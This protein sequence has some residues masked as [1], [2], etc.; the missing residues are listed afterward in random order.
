ML[1]VNQHVVPIAVDVA[2]AFAVSGK[3]VTLFTGYIETGGNPLHPAIKVVRSVTYRR[4]STLTRLWTWFA[5]SIHYLFFLL[6]RRGSEPVLVVTNPPVAPI[7]T[8][9]VS[10]VRAFTYF[11]QVYD[12]YPEALVQ[13]GFIKAD[14]LFGRWWR[15]VNRRVFNNAV[16][17][18]TLSES[19]HNALL[20]YASTP[21]IKVIHNWVDADFI[22]PIPRDQN[23]FLLERGWN[24]KTIV[25]YAGNMGLTHDLESIVDAAR[26]LRNHTNLLFL[27]VG[28]G[29]KKQKLVEM[30]RKDGLNN[31]IFLPYQS[32]KEFPLVLAA[33]DIGVV[34]LGTGGEGISVPSKTYSA[35][36][37]GT[38][39]LIIAPQESEL[40]RLVINHK[41]GIAVPPG[42]PEELAFQIES[43]VSS[44]ESLRTYQDASRKA[45]LLFSPKNAFL[46]VQDIFPDSYV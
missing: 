1:I 45:S 13:A 46:Y 42:R 37:A 16:R 2:N 28:D 24:D 44:P 33:A 34:T 38:C 29:G 36:A 9:W 43:L 23:R 31:V 15:S 10:R 30:V 39:L 41:A 21:R 7:I 35:M 8:Y 25:L 27:F 40:T 3:H 18:F 11:V 22:Q 6:L 4:Q 12:L 5:F 14:S 32:S 19:M 17:V 26:M 20:A